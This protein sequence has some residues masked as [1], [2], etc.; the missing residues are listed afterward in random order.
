MIQRIQSIFLLLAAACAFALFALPFASVEVP[1]TNVASSIFADGVYDIQDHIGTIVLFCLAGGLAFISIFLF[2]NRKLQMTL[3]RF[4]IIF[5]IIGLVL[6][7]I[8]FYN[9]VQGMGEEMPDDR[10]GIFLP[11]LFI[12]FT[13]LGLRFIGKDEKL[14]KSMDRLR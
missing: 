4:A 6:A 2:N 1:E 12:V 10:L 7:I 9:E 8:L 13:L 5:N 3:S 14:V 11:I